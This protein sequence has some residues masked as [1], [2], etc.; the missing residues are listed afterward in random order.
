MFIMIRENSDFTARNQ[1]REI[2]TN[3]GMKL[4]YN[5]YGHLYNGKIA[6]K[7]VRIDNENRSAIKYLRIGGGLLEY[8]GITFHTKG[9]FESGLK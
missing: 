2:T 7:N 6:E 1:R 5:W 3:K 4:T 9:I 8:E